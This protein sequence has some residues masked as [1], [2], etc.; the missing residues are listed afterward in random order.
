MKQTMYSGAYIYVQCKY[1]KRI[2]TR[3]S[4]H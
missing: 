4:V 1:Q 2:S 3:L